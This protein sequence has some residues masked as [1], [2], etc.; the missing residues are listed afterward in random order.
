MVRRFAAALAL[1]AAFC[2]SNLALAED[3]KVKVDGDKAAPAASAKKKIVF[4]AG[5]RSH[6]PG[7]HEHNA[8]CL[9]LAKEL[10]AGLGDQVEVEVIRDAAWPEHPAEALKDAD[11][12]VMYS[13]GGGGHMVVPR[14][15]EVDELAKQG[16]GVVCIHYAVEVEK[17][18]PGD[19]FLRWIGGYFEAHWSVNP[20]WTAE[21]TSLPE[22]PITRGVQPFKI[23]DE[24][25]YHM[26]FRDGMKGV[27]PILTAVPPESTLSRPDGPHSGNP[28]VRAEAGKPQHVAWAS[29]NEGG[30]RGFGFTGGHNHVNWADDNFRKVVL[31]AIVWTAHGEVP[32]DGVKNVKVTDEEIKANLDPKGK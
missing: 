19:A 16:V 27:T 28:F 26:R 31:N 14:I 29:E 22:H 8:G 32:A 12:I 6:G 18:K 2:F 11:T 17:G 10:E 4:I 5:K 15:D 25:Y 9:L 24:W 13:D 3:A 7:A 1:G 23:N 20:H 30:G 21:F